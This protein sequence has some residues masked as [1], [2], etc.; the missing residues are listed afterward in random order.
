MKQHITK[1]QWAELSNKEKGLF[2]YEPVIH[3]GWKKETI[4]EAV[5]LAE[6]QLEQDGK[7]P[8]IGQMIE[9]LGDDLYKIVNYTDKEW[10]VY[11]LTDDKKLYYREEELCDALFEAVKY[12]LKK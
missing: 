8:S 5:K 10:S 1:K 3:K 12:K 7:Y 9:F 4:L 11:I 6:K 2:I